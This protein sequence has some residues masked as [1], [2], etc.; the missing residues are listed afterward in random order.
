MMRVGLEKS[1]VGI[2]I[3]IQFRF[4]WKFNL[5]GYR[6]MAGKSNFLRKRTINGFNSDLKSFK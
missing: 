6:L 3:I 2:K 1:F 5:R 4:R